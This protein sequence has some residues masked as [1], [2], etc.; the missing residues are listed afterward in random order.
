MSEH[1]KSVIHRLVDEVMNAGQ[2]DVLNEL[3]PPAIARAARGWI[4]PFR[5]AFPDVHM[6][7]VD[8]VA[9]GDKVAARFTCSATQHEEWQGHVPN[10]RRFENVAEVYFFR[11]RDGKIVDVWGLEDNLDRMTQLGHLP[12]SNTTAKYSSGAP[13]GPLAP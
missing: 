7:V 1:N 4:A 8:L 13:T 2:L 6:A 3:Y 5:Q 11:F 12:A 9:E 10:G